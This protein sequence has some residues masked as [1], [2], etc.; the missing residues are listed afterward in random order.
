LVL[1]D[2]MELL[3]TK[4][5]KLQDR[6]VS[7][8]GILEH[9]SEAESVDALFRSVYRHYHIDYPKFFKMDNLCKLAL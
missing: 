8:N 1:A 9:A 4:Y 5:M 6:W 7:L 3:I 2:R